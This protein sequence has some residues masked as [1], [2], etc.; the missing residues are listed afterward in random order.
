MG[1]TLVW[2]LS[3]PHAR[4]RPLASG[5]LP[6]M[7]RLRS[8]SESKSRIRS[9]KSENLSSD[10]SQSR[11][12]KKKLRSIH[13]ESLSV[14][15]VPPEGSP[16]FWPVGSA[17]VWHRWASAISGLA[18]SHSSLASRE[19]LISMQS[20]VALVL[21]LH[22]EDR[23]RHGLQ[24][25]IPR[26]LR[27]S[28]VFSWMVLPVCFCL[29]VVVRAHGRRLDHSYVDGLAGVWKEEVRLWFALSWS[30]HPSA[31]GPHAPLLRHCVVTQHEIAS[32]YHPLQCVW[33][34]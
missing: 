25:L 6:P 8:K 17:I 30:T 3:D 16:I 5:S 32:R 27:C 11:W 33:L 14:L 22:N 28:L 24:M 1:S 31:H 20:R 12:K 23:I 4:H 19:Q 18:V 29:G 34:S 13:R 2:H 21:V 9:L 26:S 10:V 7:H 15:S